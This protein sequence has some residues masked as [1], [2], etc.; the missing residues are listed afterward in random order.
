MPDRRGEAV[1]AFA[2][3][4]PVRGLGH[5]ARQQH[6]VLDALHAG[7]GA[8]PAARIH[9]RGIHFDGGA[10]QAQHRSFA[11][12]EAAVVF[13][14]GHRGNGGFQGVAA[15]ADL[16]GAALCC[17]FAAVVIV[18]RTACAAMD[19]DGEILLCC[20]HVVLVSDAWAGG[21]T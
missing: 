5:G 10:V 3:Q 7:D 4:Q 6:R 14:Y 11:G 17:T 19:D 15:D 13:H 12:I 2:G 8:E 1:G 21:A 18:A 16:F 9:D 20:V